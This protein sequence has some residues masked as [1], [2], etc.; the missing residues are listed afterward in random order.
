MKINNTSLLVNHDGSIYHIALR[1][2]QLAD[3]VIVV[4]DPDRVPEISCFFDNLEYQVRN[5]EFVTHTG[6]YK[7]KR[8]SVLSSGIGTDNIDIVMNELDALVNVNFVTR[9]IHPRLKT[10][11]IIRLGTS[12]SIQPDIPAGAVALSSYGLGLDNL[13]HF[14]DFEETGETREMSDQLIRHTNW[15]K[16]LSRPYFVKGSDDLIRRFEK[17]TVKGITATAPGFYGPQGRVMRMQLHDP[18]LN[19]KFSTFRFRDE[20]II[21]F[22]METSALYSLGKILGH[23]MVTLCLL[24]ANRAT[25]D[26]IT[27]HKPLIR[28]MIKEVLDRLIA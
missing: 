18:E 23:N 2:D 4:G 8:I 17:G 26:Y 3:T 1:P 22:E 10:L 24:I 16:D 6:S 28:D 14:Y 11:D 9:E 12:G 13:I 15:N 27:D 20:R 25:N 5:R 21:N 7:G 19:H